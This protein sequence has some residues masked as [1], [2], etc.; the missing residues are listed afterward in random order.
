MVAAVG[1]ETERWGGGGLEEHFLPFLPGVKPQREGPD[2]V[3]KGR[4]RPEGAALEL[5]AVLS[6][7]YRE[8]PGAARRGTNESNKSGVGCPRW[9]RVRTGT[10]TGKSRG[11]ACFACF[12]SRLCGRE[13]GLKKASKQASNGA[14]RTWASPVIT[15]PAHKKKLE[16][17]KCA[18]S[19]K[20]DERS[21][22]R[23]QAWAERSLMRGSSSRLA[24]GLPTWA[25]SRLR[26]HQD[27][28]DSREPTFAE[29]KQGEKVHDGEN[30]GPS[31]QVTN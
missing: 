2:G 20:W 19:S 17:G 22:S 5:P 27:D 28:L 11:T 14:F 10:G 7:S 26:C 18:M 3:S 25:H 31:G 6:A 9:D 4:H 15:S 1:W 29:R 8:L 21:A 13:T 24:K 16:T 12:L 30:A 23:V